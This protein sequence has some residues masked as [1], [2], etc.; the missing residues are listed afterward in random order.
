[1]SNNVT[2]PS[3]EAK[4][5]E[6]H[7][8]VTPEIVQNGPKITVFKRQVRIRGSTNVILKYLKA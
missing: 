2:V 3:I 1:M 5:T 4:G 8:Q 7:I 6:S